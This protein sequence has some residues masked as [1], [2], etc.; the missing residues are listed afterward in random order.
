[1]EF[2]ELYNLSERESVDIGGWLISDGDATDRVTAWERAPGDS[3]G[4]VTIVSGTTLLRPN[5]YALVFDPEYFQYGEGGWFDVGEST[6]VVTVENTTLG[7]GLSTKD[8]LIL[9]NADGDTVSTFGTPGWDDGFPEDPGDGI[10]WERIDPSGAD[11]DRNWVVSED[12]SGSTPG[13]RNSLSIP[14]NLSV[15]GS[16][17][18]ID[19]Q[20][21]EEGSTVVVTGIIRNAGIRVVSAFEVRFFLDHDRDGLPVE[22]EIQHREFIGGPI[23]PGDSISVSGFLRLGGIGY[24]TMG[25]EAVHS[26]D[27][28]ASDNTVTR[29]VKVGRAASRVVVNE[30]YYD[31]RS[32]EEE[33]VE[34]FN[35]SE[36]S[37]DLSGWK[38]SD[39][40]TTG[41]IADGSVNIDRGT[42]AVLAGDSVK[43]IEGF[44]ELVDRSVV[45]VKPFPSLGNRGDTLFLETSDGYVSDRVEYLA[46]WGG[47]DGISL[48]RVNPGD[49]TP[50]PSNWGSSVETRGSTPCKQNSIYQIVERNE[51]S[52]WVTPEIFSPDGDGRDDRV[53]ISYRL[54]V[55]KARLKMEIFNVLGN[56][57]K[58][59]LDQVESGSEG[60]AVWDG[61]D[62]RGRTLPIGIYVVYIEAIDS[63]S[64]FLLRKKESVVLGGV[65]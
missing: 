7:D 2:I 59:I 16:P 50:G 49:M 18:T 34:I 32:G 24:Y 36:G 29:E 9:W 47:G 60:L 53:V 37:L 65:L 20:E 38:F 58:V 31:P 22:G 64:G 55:P 26:E 62:S 51:A 57:V 30:I 4:N 39:N 41:Q 42:Y 13:R 52:L 40:K 19:P 46:Q 17:L 44:P 5:R 56:R 8:P 23:T 45:E 11:E 14:L 54:P 25:M 35:R 48:E 61:K 33:W 63:Y 27:G 43:L 28:D 12:P 15:S 21:P 3:I 1:M 6:L 10:S